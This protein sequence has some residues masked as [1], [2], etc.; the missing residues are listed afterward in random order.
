MTGWTDPAGELGPPLYR[1]ELSVVAAH[2][3]LVVAGELDIGTGPCLEPYLR[4]ALAA[5]AGGRPILINLDRVTFCDLAGLDALIAAQ[6]AVASSRIAVIAAADGAVQPGGIRRLLALLEQI[7]RAET[8][9]T[10]HPTTSVALAALA[11]A[12]RPRR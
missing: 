4:R 2:V 12:D 3:D 1:A 6:A 7:G 5:A 10:L 9:L 8:R 11:A